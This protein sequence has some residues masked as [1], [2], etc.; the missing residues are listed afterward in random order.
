[1]RPGAELALLDRRGV[2]DEFDQIGRDAAVRGHRGALGS[3]AITHHALALLLQVAQQGHE[4]VTRLL[5]IASQGDIG[6]GL[7][8]AEDVFLS[9]L[10]RNR[11]RHRAR[12]PVRD[13]IAHRSAMHV[14]RQ[15]VDHLEAVLP[16]QVA[17]RCDGEIEGVL[18]VDLVI[19]NLLHDVAEV[20]VLEHQH[21]LGLQ[22]NA[23]A[24]SHRMQVGNVTHHV[25]AKER[26]GLPMLGDDAPRQVFIEEF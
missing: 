26:I 4:I 12:L 9:A 5:D 17:D 15:D 11:R 24:F 10:C 23:D 8:Q 19:G 25:G 3:G 16:E 20:R 7:V 2:A 6:F 21:A 18:V 14:L 1:V 13:D 22:Q